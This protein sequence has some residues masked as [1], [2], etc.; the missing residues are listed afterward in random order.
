M[1]NGSEIDSFVDDTK[2]YAALKLTDLARGLDCL[3]TDLNKVAGWCCYNQLLINPEKTQYI[4][5]GTRQVSTI[6]TKTTRSS[7]AIPR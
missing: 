6:T 2:L 5:F 3:M 1:C 4:L 7:P